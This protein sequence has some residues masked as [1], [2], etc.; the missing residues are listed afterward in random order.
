MSY[1]VTIQDTVL[2]KC[3]EHVTFNVDTPNHYD[4]R[5]DPK[6]SMII[7]GKIDTDEGTALLYKWA[8]LPA[9]NSDCYKE[10]TIEYTK[11]N[12]LVRK[13]CFPKAFVVDYSENYSNYS[14]V[15]T[16]KLYVRQFRGKDIECTGQTSRQSS[17]VSNVTEEVEKELDVVKQQTPLATTASNSK[18]TMSITDKIANQKEMMD[19]DITGANKPEIELGKADLDALRKKWKVPE[20]DT[21]AVGK[22]DVPVLEGISFEGGSPKVRAEAGFPNYDVS[23]PD[24]LIKSS[25]KIPSAT[26]HAEEVVANEHQ[27]L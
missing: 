7:T 21:I 13:V 20:T 14:G 5:T 6:N 16:F 4:M 27:R 9:T 18:S 19:N 10:I 26:R 1:K 3:I 12:Q 22:T 8:L 23:H 11:D 17:E 25:G 24:R 2:E 15:G